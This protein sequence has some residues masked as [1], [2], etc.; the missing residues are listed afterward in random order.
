VVD[1][2]DDPGGN[3]LGFYNAQDGDA[4]VL[5]QLADQ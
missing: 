5:K 1:A 4:P 3:S 2:R